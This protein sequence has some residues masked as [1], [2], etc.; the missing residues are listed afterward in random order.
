M[1]HDRRSTSTRARATSRWAVML[2][3]AAVF[4]GLVLAPSADARSRVRHLAFAPVAATRVLA[5]GPRVL[6][7]DRTL[8][9]ERTNAQTSITPPPG[10]VASTIGGPWIAAGCDLDSRTPADIAP[11]PALYSIATGTWRAVALAPS[12][13]AFCANAEDCQIRSVGRHWLGIYEQDFGGSQIVFQN[14]TSGQVRPD[15]TAST[16]LPD[17]NSATLARTVCSPLRVP[18]STEVGHDPTPGSLIFA[19]RF[20]VATTS[21]LPSTTSVQRCG[22]RSRT[23]VCHCDPGV[24]GNLRSVAINA[25][26]VIWVPPTPEGAPLGTAVTHLDGMYLP[27]RQRFVIPLPPDARG[28]GTEALL[29]S[30]RSLYI[31][32]SSDGSR[33]FRARSPR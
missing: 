2:A 19:G 7:G 17:L 28:R 25:H 24:V 11:R 10:C 14:L 12:I 30:S 15:P 21:S 4:G 23:F 16:T 9:D 33:M 5:D 18:P 32:N 6:L 3:L 20:A 26:V 13:A 29:L 8:I 27:G 22:S 31:Q 1:T